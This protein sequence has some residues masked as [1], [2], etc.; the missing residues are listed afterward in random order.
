MWGLPFWCIRLNVFWNFIFFIVFFPLF[1]F[2]IEACFLNY[3]ECLRVLSQLLLWL[4]E[5]TDSPS[6]R[7][8]SPRWW[9]ALSTWSL[10]LS[11][12]PVWQRLLHWEVDVLN[13]ICCKVYRCSLSDVLRRV[14]TMSSLHL[15]HLTNSWQ[16]E[17]VELLFV[18][19]LPA[20]STNVSV[21][22]C[23][24]VYLTLTMS[25][26]NYLRK[27]SIQ[28]C[29]IWTCNMLKI[30]KTW[31][32]GQPWSP[33]LQ[34]HSKNHFLFSNLSSKVKAQLFFIAAMFYTGLNYRAFNFEVVNLGLKIV[35]IALQT[36][37]IANMQCMKT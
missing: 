36:S 15:V 33:S 17:V 19:C 30:N 31:I 23:V 29:V 6:C 27:F 14:Q 35:S 20:K 22:L 24:C 9:I 32:N 7:S 21:C 5:W 28:C 8:Q 13:W 34:Q 4:V 18:H 25:F 2:S 16:K 26:V 10:F 12:T 1:I 11:A 37:E 3:E